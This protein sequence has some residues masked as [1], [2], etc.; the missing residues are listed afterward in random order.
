VHTELAR[1]PR[2]CARSLAKLA[3]FLVAEGADGDLDPGQGEP[4]VVFSMDEFRPL[5]LQPSVRTGFHRL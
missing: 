1:D 4:T 2:D 3:D 5:N